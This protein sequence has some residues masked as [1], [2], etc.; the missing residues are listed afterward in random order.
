MSA[1]LTL[2]LVCGLMMSCGNEAALNPVPGPGDGSKF[3]EC[4]PCF[5]TLV[6]ETD[7]CGPALDA[8]LDDP[9]LELEPIVVCFQTEGVCFDDALQRSAM[10]NNSCGDASQAQVELCAGQCF[11]QR[12]DCAEQAVRGTDACLSVCGGASCEQCTLNGQGAFD[13]CNSRL[14]ECSDRCVRTFRTD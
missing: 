13:Q 7:V 6:E 4:S 2:A 10:C 9:T 11:R 1:R 5:D 3:A 14:T 12:A 8:C